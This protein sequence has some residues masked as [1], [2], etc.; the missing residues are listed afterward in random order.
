MDWLDFTTTITDGMAYWPD[1]APVHIKRTL[2]MADGAAAN[3][4]EISMSVHTGTHVDAPLHFLADGTDAAQLDLS[5]LM[6]PALLVAVNS[7]KFISRADV[8][9]LQLKPGSRVLFK[10]RNS[11]REWSTEPFN[12]DFVRV[13]ADAAAWLQEQGVVCVGVDYLSV[14]DAQAHNILLGAGISVIE[15]LALQHAEPGEYELLCLPLKIK[16][17]DGAPA[18]V[19]ARRR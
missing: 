11:A 1:N 17:V 10:T 9:H 12:P 16:G 19:L 4:S 13:G 6:G 2:S 7:E 14:G 8:E 3:V 15:G 5:K 18:R